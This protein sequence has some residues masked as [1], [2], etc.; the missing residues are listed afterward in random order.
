MTE[1][2]QLFG[3]SIAFVHR[4]DGGS[5]RIVNQFRPL[6]TQ[7]LVGTL[8]RFG[9]LVRQAVTPLP[10]FTFRMPHQCAAIVSAVVLSHN[11]YRVQVAHYYT[12][13]QSP[14]YRTI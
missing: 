12:V 13:A 11:G 8:Q 1:R 7:L 3:E 2:G 5:V 9:Q 4:F 14:T 6:L 10:T